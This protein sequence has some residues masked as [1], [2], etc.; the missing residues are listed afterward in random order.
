M[1]AILQVRMNSSRL[2]GKAL[3]PVLGRPLLAYNIE[4]IQQAQAIDRVVVATSSAPADDVIAAHCATWGTP[5]FRGSQDDVLDRIYRCAR[6]FGMEVFAKLTADNPLIDPGVI[7]VVVAAFHAGP[8]PFDYFSNNHPPTWPDGQEVEIIRTA[9]LEC[10]WRE[11]REAFQREHVTVLLWDQPERF[12]VGNLALGDDA[13]YRRHRWT[14]DFPEDYELVRR[15]FEALYPS[16]SGFGIE[17]ITALLARQP[18]LGALNQQHKG[19]VWYDQHQGALQT[20]ARTP[21]SG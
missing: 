12:R 2:P 4:R 20:M 3:L 19:V 13:L 10:A 7:D 6:H 15:V 17:Q 16:H 21:A 8:A 5:V 9:A 18:E 1:D 11:S 14:M